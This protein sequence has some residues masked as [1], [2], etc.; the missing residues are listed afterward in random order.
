[1]SEHLKN[2]SAAADAVD[3]SWLPEN[4]TEPIRIEE[5]AEA[6][7]A[8]NDSVYQKIVELVQGCLPF[9]LIL[10]HKNLASRN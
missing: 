4:P 9:Y 5:R 10:P 3:Y 6:E 7:L 2:M 1:M 8:E